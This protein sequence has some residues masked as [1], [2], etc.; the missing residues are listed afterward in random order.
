[1]TAQ[2]PWLVPQSSWRHYSKIIKGSRGDLHV[3]CQ[4]VEM[5]RIL[6]FQSVIPRSWNWRTSAHACSCATTL[7]YCAAQYENGKCVNV[8]PA[9]SFR[10]AVRNTS[11]RGKPTASSNLKSS[12]KLALPMIVALSQLKWAKCLQIKGLSSLASMP[13][14]FFIAEAAANQE[15]RQV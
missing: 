2:L 13:E 15:L 8:D 9:N 4:P 1:M 12:V 3:V 7:N 14:S 10:N 11:N 6:I 5:Y